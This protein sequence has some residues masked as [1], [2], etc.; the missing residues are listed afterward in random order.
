MVNLKSRG[1]VHDGS[2]EYR[3]DRHGGP[4]RHLPH[5]WLDGGNR[6]HIGHRERSRLARDAFSSSSPDFFACICSP[7]SRA[8][9]DSATSAS[10]RFRVT[11]TSC[12]GSNKFRQMVVGLRL[13][14]MRRLHALVDCPI[15]L[16]QQI[17]NQSL[18][19]TKCSTPV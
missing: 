18:P 14:Q 10:R 12:Q 4:F 6:A 13:T 8:T 19:P 15:D 3:L 5:H 11:I 9:R 16:R 2:R 17:R 7:G 1:D